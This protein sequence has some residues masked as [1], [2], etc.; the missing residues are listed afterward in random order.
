MWDSTH[1][2]LL[3]ETLPAAAAG[4][5]RPQTRHSYAQR[6]AWIS[7]GAGG[8]VQAATPIWVRTET[9][10]CRTSAATG[11]PSSP[12]AAGALDEVR[13]VYDYGPNSGPN[14]LLLRGQAVTAE[15]GG[16]LVTHRSCY[17]YDA[18]GRRVSETQPNAN[19]STCP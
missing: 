4:Q 6:H 14:N 11:N 8:Y 9:S 17:G 1:G 18:R 15:V 3:S 2:E 5:P 16:Q 12:C 10:S 13:T 19:L 7:N